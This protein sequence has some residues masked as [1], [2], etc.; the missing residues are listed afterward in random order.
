MR[1]KWLSWGLVMAQFGCLAALGATGTVVARS[2]LLLA[3]QAV[4]L[5]LAGW[6][7]WAMRDSL[8]HALPDVRPNARLVS[9]GPFAVIRHPLYASLLMLTLAIVLDDFT[10]LRAGIWL[11]L[12]VVL[13]IKL[14]YEEQLLAE[15][16]PEYA[17]YR[18]RTWR[19]IPFVF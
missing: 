5:A 11:A 9:S 17:A 16:F 13:V 12:F 18:Q 3:V 4:G 15:R 10:A 19:L 8:P 2:A 14:S 1:R 7:L 6:A